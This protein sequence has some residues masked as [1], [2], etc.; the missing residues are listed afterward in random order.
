MRAAPGKSVGHKTSYDTAR[1]APACAGSVEVCGVDTTVD[2]QY[3]RGVSAA[4]DTAYAYDSAALLVG[5]NIAVVSAVLECKCA[6]GGMYAE[7]LAENTARAGVRVA[8]T[9]GN[10]EGDDLTVVYA[11]LE[12]QLNRSASCSFAN[13]TACRHTCLKRVYKCVVLTSNEG[14]RTCGDSADH[15]ANAVKKRGVVVLGVSFCLNVDRALGDTVI[16]SSVA[17]YLAEEETCAALEAVSLGKNDHVRVNGDVGE[18]ARRLARENAEGVGLC[19][20]VACLYGEAIH[21]TVADL[22]KC[23]K[24]GSGNRNSLAVTVKRA[25]EVSVKGR[26][27]LDVGGKIIRSCRIHSQKLICCVDRRTRSS[28]R[29]YNGENRCEHQGYDNENG[30]NS[31]HSLLLK[32]IFVCRL[33]PC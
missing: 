29:G 30:K 24:S 31:F 3:C 26:G 10:A 18:H 1:S 25:L 14:N 33:H 8:L 32:Y 12:A 13:E 4:Y 20:L 17:D 28:G 22:L 16:E 9:R 23:G 7:R 6:V 19:Y 15:T 21:L 27:K 2:I 11:V 5:V